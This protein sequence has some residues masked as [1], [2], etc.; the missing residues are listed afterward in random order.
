MLFFEKSVRASG[1]SAAP[2]FTRCKVRVLGVFRLSIQHS[3]NPFKVE[4]YIYHIHGSDLIYS[5]PASMRAGC[6]TIN[7]FPI[8]CNRLQAQKTFFL[9]SIQTNMISSRVCT[10][11]IMCAFTIQTGAKLQQLDSSRELDM[12]DVKTALESTYILLFL[13]DLLR[14]IPSFMLIAGE[15]SMWLSGM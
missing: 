14:L 3:F 1:S 8:S 15:K 2:I 13:I 6:G 11:L 12:E 5:S 7:H 10:A 4:S 9:S